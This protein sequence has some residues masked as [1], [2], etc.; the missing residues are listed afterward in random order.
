MLFVFPPETFVVALSDYDRRYSN[1]IDVKAGDIVRPVIDGSMETDFMGWTWC[2]GPDGRAGWTPD[3]WC[4]PT[5]EGWQISR[6][7]CALE[8]TVRTG[9]RL[10]L[11]YSESGFL[12]CE[13]DSGERA[14]VPDAVMRLAV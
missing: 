12:F 6:D 5:D 10:R 14:W 9:D 8:L 4:L 13:T 1:P 7:F 2:V 11:I 3:S